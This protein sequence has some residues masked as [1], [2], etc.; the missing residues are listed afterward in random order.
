M[1]DAPSFKV[2]ALS[3]KL[4]SYIIISFTTAPPLRLCSLRAFL[5]APCLT[6]AEIPRN[7]HRIVGSQPLERRAT[8]ALLGL[9]FLRPD[10]NVE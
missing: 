2:A 10:A 3:S 6:C 8:L 1:R 4:V 9:P 7:L 5:G